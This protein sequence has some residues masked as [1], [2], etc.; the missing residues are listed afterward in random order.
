MPSSGRVSI[1]YG[2]M[3]TVDV[4]YYRVKDLNMAHEYYKN[5]T[6]DYFKVSKSSISREMYYLST[7]DRKKKVFFK[8]IISIFDR[9]FKSVFY[10]CP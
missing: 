4:V 5:E 1:T 2:H 8:F 6:K 9:L 10:L 3:L 7:A